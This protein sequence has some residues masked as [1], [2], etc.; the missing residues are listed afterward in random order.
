MTNSNK[1]INIVLLTTLAVSLFFLNNH[2]SE[3][4]KEQLYM[5]ANNETMSPQKLFDESWK[6]I[7]RNYYDPTLNQQNWYYWK[8]HYSK[9]IKTKE[10]AFVAIDSMLQSLNDPYSQFL[11][12][13]EVTEQTI[14]LNSK[15]T[16][17]GV[18][19]LTVSGKFIIVGIIDNSPAQKSGIKAGDIISKIDG[20]DTKGKNITDIAN[21]IRGEKNSIVELE[22]LRENEKLT[23]KLKREEIKIQTIKAE[24]LPDDIGYIK[25]STFMNTNLPKEFSE[26]LRKVSSAKGLIVDLRNNPGGL[27][28]NAIILANTF[29]NKGAIVHIKNRNQ[30]KFSIVADANMPHL[31]VPMIILINKG[32]ASASEIFSGALKD[33]NRAVLVG[34]K[35]YGKGMIQKVYNLPNKTGLNITNAKYLTP[36]GADI[37][38]HGIEPHY[39][40]KNPETYTKAN[41]EQLKKAI[42]VLK[43]MI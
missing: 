36:L 12:P 19:L 13:E 27:L 6:I 32:S 31:T 1:F 42:S 4:Q 7:K 2:L 39:N 26:G 22:L 24:L 35:T 10:D 34:E 29:I 43:A 41:D 25:I 23:K 18:N 40:I 15:I 33:Y 3:I 16:G 20:N 21:A 37:N 28:E 11:T 9:K 38:K 30:Q 17:I 8:K 5:H 14:D